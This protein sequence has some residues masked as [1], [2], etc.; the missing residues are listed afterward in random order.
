MLAICA[1]VIFSFCFIHIVESFSCRCHTITIFF[2]CL[3]VIICKIWKL[4]VFSKNWIFSWPWFIWI[5]L[6]IRAVLLNHF[7]NSLNTFHMIICIKTSNYVLNNYL[8]ISTFLYCCYYIIGFCI[9]DKCI[10]TVCCCCTLNFMSVMICKAFNY[11]AKRIVICH[12]ISYKQNIHCVIPFVCC[13][14]FHPFKKG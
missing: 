12:W 2:C 4:T 13:I 6:C 7:S 3:Y 5:N 14:C 9:S 11:A 1:V 8:V 10:A